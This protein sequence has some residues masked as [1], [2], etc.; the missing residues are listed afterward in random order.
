MLCPE[1]E[2]KIK[3][4]EKLTVDKGRR[5]RVK[6]YIEE[7]VESSREVVEETPEVPV[8]VV[9][10]EV[11]A[12]RESISAVDSAKNGGEA[13]IPSGEAVNSSIA[14][15]E[16]SHYPTITNLSDPY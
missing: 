13:A 11:V 6:V 2:S 3:N 7:M 15:I 16:V 1:C 12:G 10:E 5:E 14:E 9:E 4:L 8:E